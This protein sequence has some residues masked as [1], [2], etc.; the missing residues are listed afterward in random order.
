MKI[1]E[2]EER[3]PRTVAAEAI[4]EAAEAEMSDATTGEEAV[5]I[6]VRHGVD[7]RTAILLARMRHEY[8]NAEARLEPS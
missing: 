4:C 6:Y 2:T 1:V 5:E 7:E 3:D 8:P